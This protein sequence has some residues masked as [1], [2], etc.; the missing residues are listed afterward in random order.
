MEIKKAKVGKIGKKDME[1]YFVAIVND[2]GNVVTSATF[3]HEEDADATAKMLKGFLNHES[4][5]F[6][7][8]EEMFHMTDRFFKKLADDEDPMQDDDEQLLH[9]MPTSRETYWNFC[10][11]MA[12]AIKRKLAGK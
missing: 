1:C 6:M 10:Q 2:S 8:Y 5:P 4:I 12:E 9:K 3:L 11:Q 7:P